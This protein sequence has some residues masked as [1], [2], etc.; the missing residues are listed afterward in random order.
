MKKFKKSDNAVVGIVAAFLIVGLIVAVLSVIQTQYVPK[1][2]REK[3]S[4]HMDELAD[5]FAQL[6]YA[7]NTHVLNKVPNIPIST[8]ITLGS[9]EMPY[10][11]STKAF[12]Q[13]K[14]LPNNFILNISG[15]SYYNESF[16]TIEYN[17]FNSYFI[18]QDYIYECGGVILNQDSGNAM[19]I[20]PNFEA[21]LQ[22]DIAITLNVVNISTIGGKSQ[23]VQGYGPA[24]IQTEYIAGS[25]KSMT[26]A[27][28]SHINITS[29]YIQT[30]NSSL[31]SKFRINGLNHPGFVDYEIITKED[32][33]KL[34]IHF[35]LD[36]KVIINYVEIGAQIAPGWVEDR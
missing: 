22:T 30:W 5:Q 35:L 17:S 15:D 34:V 32:E 25:V 23:C 3:E 27:N 7:I 13:L 14:I 11:M 21:L 29:N 10:L 19:Y 12:G 6:N 9:K 1:W 2:M 33:N 4:D 8:T 20:R 24:P 31:N 36:T 18:D 26:I 28:V 16:G